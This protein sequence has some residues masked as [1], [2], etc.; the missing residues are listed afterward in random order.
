MIKIK[1]FAVLGIF[2]VFL[3]SILL[4][5]AANYKEELQDTINTIT[6]LYREDKED[7]EDKEEIIDKNIT[8]DLT[9]KSISIIKTG[10]PVR[11]KVITSKEDMEKVKNFVESIHLE[12]KIKDQIKGWSYSIDITNANNTNVSLTIGLCVSYGDSQYTFDSSLCEK[13]DDIYNELNYPEV[14]PLK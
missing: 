10:N 3:G 4:F 14:D 13:F 1:K 7:K 11:K 6:T 5:L 8:L 12:K 2:I 9:P